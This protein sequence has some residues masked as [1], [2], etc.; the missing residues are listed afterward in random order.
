VA[1]PAEAL[2]TTV[3]LCAVIADECFA[4]FAPVSDRDQNL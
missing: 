1:E 4:Q 2:E 3:E